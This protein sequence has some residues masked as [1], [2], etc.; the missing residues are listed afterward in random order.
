MVGIPL[1]MR[2]V[3]TNFYFEYL[4]L[5]E[6]MI[7]GYKIVTWIFH[8][9]CPISMSYLRCEM[10]TIVSFIASFHV[11][12]ISG[13]FSD[14][15]FHIQSICTSCF[16]TS[17]TFSSAGFSLDILLRPEHWVPPPLPSPIWILN[18][19]YFLQ[20]RQKSS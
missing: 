7:P 3:K 10:H 5:I 17:P 11:F 6:N 1:T 18:K 19:E 15:C 14:K 12:D 20:D 16:L 8:I 13:T 9:F 4:N 2:I